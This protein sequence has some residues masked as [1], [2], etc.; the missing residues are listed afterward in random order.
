M[1]VSTSQLARNIQ[2]SSILFTLSHISLPHFWILSASLSISQHAVAPGN[3][4]PGAVAPA[5]PSAA[6]PGRSRRPSSH[7]N[8]PGPRNLGTRCSD[9]IGINYGC[10]GWIPWMDS[11][12]GFDGYGFDG[13]G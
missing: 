1:F 7:P 6:A 10:H 13:Y 4:A 9:I 2:T 12:D 5:L 8:A 11:M 3:V